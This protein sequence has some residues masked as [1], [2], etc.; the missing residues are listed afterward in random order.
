MSD[1]APP[2]GP[3]PPKAPE[4]PEGWLAQWN[5]QYKEW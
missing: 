5:D 4:V 2:P 3:P 1:F